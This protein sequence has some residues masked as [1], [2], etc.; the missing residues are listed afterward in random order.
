MLGPFLWAT[1][2]RSCA[3]HNRP[4]CSV[5]EAARKSGAGVIVVGTHAR[6]A[7]ASAVLGSVAKQLL[8]ASP[9]P[10]LAVPVHAK[11]KTAEPVGA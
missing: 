9:C 7:I 2:S 1:G 8:H 10:V 11:V 5:R 3:E 4:A 6:G